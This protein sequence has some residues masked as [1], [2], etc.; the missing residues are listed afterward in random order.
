MLCRHLSCKWLRAWLL[1]G[2]SV[3]VR[4]ISGGLPS[5]CSRA[6][7]KKFN[8]AGTEQIK[9]VEQR[10]GLRGWGLRVLWG[11]EPPICPVSQAE[12]YFD[13]TGV[14]KVDLKYLESPGMMITE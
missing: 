1:V 10:L 2:R 14:T 3:S 7:H 5:L 9:G 13:K 12:R 8:G 6:E 4:F 11:R